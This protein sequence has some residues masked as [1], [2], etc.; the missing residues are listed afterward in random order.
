MPRTP[1]FNPVETP[2]GWMVSVPPS[3]TAKGKR[4][5]RYFP[6]KDKATRFAGRIK[7]IYQGGSRSGMI[8][9][10]LAT[11]AKQAAAI[12]E[13]TGISLI[14]AARLA[15]KPDRECRR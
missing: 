11:E 4:K 13:G 5:R 3:L 1:D 12:L 8:D 9:A 14:E 7:T 6:S 10:S 15:K 2:R